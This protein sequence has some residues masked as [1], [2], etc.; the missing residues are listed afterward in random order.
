MY[1]AK[2]VAGE[3]TMP[4]FRTLP[5]RLGMLVLLTLVGC[6]Q[7]QNAPSSEKRSGLTTAQQSSW[8]DVRDKTDPATWLRAY[9]GSKQPSIDEQRLRQTLSVAALRF[10]ESS[11]MIANRAVQLENML[12]PLGGGESA[13]S[14]ISDLSEAI[15]DSKLVPGFGTVGQ[16][17][18]NLRK[19]GFDGPQA[20]ND[21]SRRYGSHD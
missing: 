13:I 5:P 19:A 21:L 10:G 15:G 12:Q 20:I 4:T 16:Y 2:Q 3:A 8:L 14:L 17:Y 9:E 18:Y 6:D 1:A 11:R 7:P